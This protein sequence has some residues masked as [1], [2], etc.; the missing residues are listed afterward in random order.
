MQIDTKH[1]ESLLERVTPG[2][3]EFSPQD[4]HGP[5]R[6]D[7][8]VLDGRGVSLAEVYQTESDQETNA[9]AELMAMSKTLARR[10][11]AAEKLAEAL[12][13]M[14]SEYG[15]PYDGEFRYKGDTELGMIS[16]AREALSEWENMK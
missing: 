5:H 16:E 2:E 3:W 8:E 13:E 10:V 9:N 7:A 14:L 15:A 12:G 11:I 4:G 1:L 6:F